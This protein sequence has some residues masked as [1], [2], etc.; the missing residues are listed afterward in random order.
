MGDKVKIT[1]D[2]GAGELDS[3]VV[4]EAKAKDALLKMIEELGCV[5][6]GDT[7]TVRYVD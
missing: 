3:V 6:E 2:N 1:L 4:D 5:N 7:F